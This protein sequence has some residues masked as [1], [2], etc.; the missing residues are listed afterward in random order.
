M[1]PRNGRNSTGQTAYEWMFGRKIRTKPGPMKACKRKDIDVRCTRNF[2]QKF[3]EHKGT[4]S[5]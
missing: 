5:W 3:K 1:T 4:Q 2:S